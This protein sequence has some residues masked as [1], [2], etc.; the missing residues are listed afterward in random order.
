MA[1][2]V[3][4]EY[5]LYRNAG[6]YASPTWTEIT[7][8]LDLTLTLDGEKVDFSTRASKFKKYLC[9]MIDLAIAWSMLDNSAD[10]S[11]TTIQT[12]FAARA[13]T[14]EFAVADA[15]IASAGTMWW[16]TALAAITKM[17]RGEPLN[18]AATRDIEACPAAGDSNEPA[19]TTT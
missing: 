14:I 2:R 11:M 17:G 9:G 19:L 3:G 13:A 10:T 6:S 4:F 16:R 5:K 12:A 7:N 15:A 8:C 18:G 1:V